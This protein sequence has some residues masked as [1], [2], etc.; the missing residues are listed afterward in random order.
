MAI[1][2][3]FLRS[4]PEAEIRAALPELYPRLRRYALSLSGNRPE[5]EDL[6]QET[7]AQ[8]LLRAEQF[9]PGSH[10]DRWMFTILYRLWLNRMRAR[11]V[12]LGLGNVP[13][14]EAGLTS[15]DDP[16]AT[17]FGAEVLGHVMALPEAQRQAVILV[18]VEGI[19][20]RDVAELTDAKIGTV[21]S[22]LAAAR[23]K[24]KQR[25]GEP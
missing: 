24:L 5:A 20:Y 9:R 14:E 15:P 10:V 7:V 16:E 13:V 11:K 3:N 6:V 8:A 23:R 2:R 21:M 17:C 1:I 25:L 22:R 19:S 4:R 18:C 12:R